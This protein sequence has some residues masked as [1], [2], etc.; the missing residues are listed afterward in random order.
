MVAV[1]FVAEH[2]GVVSAYVFFQLLD[3]IAYVRHL[4]VDASS[5]RSGLGRLLMNAVAKCARAS[6]ATRWMLNAVPSNTAAIALYEGLGMVRGDIAHAVSVPWDVV[7]AHASEPAAV[8]VRPLLDSEDAAA[9]RHF[10]LAPGIVTAARKLEGRVFLCARAAPSGPLVGLAVFDA[11]FPGA[12]PF[13]ADSGEI[14][15][16]LLAGMAP[17]RRLEDRTVNVREEG[18]PYLTDA[19]VRAGARVRL[20]VVSLSGQLPA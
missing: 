16:A 11:A 6:G 5:R 19:L 12:S 14:A 20:E 8:C 17:N 15:F 18:Q 3:G 7:F 1:M 2:E 4:V 10:G 13:R 9:E